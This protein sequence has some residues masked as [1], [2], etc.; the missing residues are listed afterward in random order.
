MNKNLLLQYSDQKIIFPTSEGASTH[1]LTK[2]TT[3]NYNQQLT[4]SNNNNNSNIK[5]QIIEQEES[6]LKLKAIF[7]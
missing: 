6:E 3:D 2:N 4:I 7:D 5:G 1:A